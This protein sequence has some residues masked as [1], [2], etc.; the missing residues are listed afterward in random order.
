MI[1]MRLTQ[2][3]YKYDF[4]NYF[5]FGILCIRISKIIHAEY[6]TLDKSIKFTKIERKK[7]RSWI[8]SGKSL[9]IQLRTFTSGENGIVSVVRKKN[10]MSQR[11]RILGF[12]FWVIRN[13][14][15]N[16]NEFNI[17]IRFCCSLSWGN[18]RHHY[19]LIATFKAP[20]N[21]A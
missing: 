8:E 21:G 6:F 19:K 13:G 1:K 10:A 12:S 3:L 20:L 17:Y 7:C 4:M 5:N 9:W 11:S 2:T 18:F 14:K 15:N 16:L